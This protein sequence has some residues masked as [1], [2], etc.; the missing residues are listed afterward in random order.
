MVQRE[1]GGVGIRVVCVD[2]GDGMGLA[3]GECFQQFLCLT[4][5]LTEVRVSAQ[6]TR[7]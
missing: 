7:W 5:E 1:V 2:L 6:R 4:P 3:R